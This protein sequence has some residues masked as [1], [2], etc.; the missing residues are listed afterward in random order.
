MYSAASDTAAAT[1][2]ISRWM[3][4]A[5]EKARD[6]VA[7]SEEEKGP[8]ESKEALLGSELLAMSAHF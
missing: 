2:I 6:L 5:A 1:F 7:L 4:W 8:M 3:F